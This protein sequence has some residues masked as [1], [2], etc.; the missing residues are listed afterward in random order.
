VLFH[1]NL[2]SYILYGY[3]LPDLPAAYLWPQA[4]DLSQSLTDET[5][6]ALGI[7]QSEIW[8]IPANQPGRIWLIWVDNPH[9]SQAEVAAARVALAWGRNPSLVETIR[10]DELVT[11]KVW[12]LEAKAK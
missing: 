2:S 3:Y 11:A 6:S 5:K 9:I 7:R 8:D 12:L 10:D 1:M 4:N